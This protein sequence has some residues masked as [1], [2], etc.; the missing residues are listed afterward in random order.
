MACQAG[1]QLMGRSQRGGDFIAKAVDQFVPTRVGF[2][3]QVDRLA[4]QSAQADGHALLRAE[5]PGKVQVIGDQ[6]IG[7]RLLVALDLGRLEYAAEVG[8]QVFGFY[9][10]DQGVVLA[11]Q[12][13]GFVFALGGFGLVGGIQPGKAGPDQLRQCRAVRVLSRVAPGPGLG[14]ARYIVFDV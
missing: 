13:V 10:A 8:V 4:A 11:H 3:M 7:K 12:V 1:S 5:Q 9:V 14:Q 2:R 6:Q